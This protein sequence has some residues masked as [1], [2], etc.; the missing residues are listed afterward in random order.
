MQI[1]ALVLV[2]DESPAFVA[3]TGVVPLDRGDH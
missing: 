3:V 2:E 1:V